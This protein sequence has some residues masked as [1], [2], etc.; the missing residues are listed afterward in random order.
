MFKIMYSGV[1]KPHQICI[2]KVLWLLPGSHALPGL[3]AGLNATALGLDTSGR[4]TGSQRG[5]RGFWRASCC[6][7]R[8]ERSAS[9]LR[10]T[11]LDASLHIAHPIRQEFGLHDLKEP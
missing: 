7:C 8:W 1:G 10:A 2:G 4:G 3:A 11:T 6:R 9:L 5:G